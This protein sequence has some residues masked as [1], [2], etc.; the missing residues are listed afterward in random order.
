MT[1]LII[2]FRAAVVVGVVG[3]LGWCWWTMAGQPIP[4]F[5]T[6]QVTTE[7]IV[8]IESSCKGDSVRDVICRAAKAARVPVALSHAVAMVEG[9][10]NAENMQI[11]CTNK[12]WAKSHRLEDCALGLYQIIPSQNGIKDPLS[13]IGPDN[14]RRNISEGNKILRSHFERGTGKDISAK[15]YQALIRYYGAEQ[16]KYQQRVMAMASR[17]ALEVEG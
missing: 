7:R 17:L 2:Y 11:N 4:A 1:K 3:M 13:I 10:G 15:W 14:L 12:M 16:D 9:G 5:M 8:E 6:K